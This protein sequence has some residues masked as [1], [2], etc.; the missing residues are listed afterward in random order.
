MPAV[1]MFGMIAAVFAIAVLVSWLYL[2]RTYWPRKSTRDFFAFSDMT[3]MQKL[4]GYFYGVRPDLYLKPAKWPWAVKK[5]EGTTANEYH[6]KVITRRDAAK[7]VKLDRPVSFQASEKVI[8]FPVARSI[9]LEGAPPLAVMECPCRAQKPDACEPR[10]VCMVV[11]EPFVS[12]VLEHR[13]GHARRITTEEA[14]GI[15]EQEEKRGHIH[16][17]WFKT[18][19]HDRFYTICNCCTCCCLGMA[20]YHRDVP[21]ITH[22]GYRPVNDRDGCIECGE[23]E[24]S[25]PFRAVICLEGSPQIN[26]NKCMGCG[27]CVSHCPVGAIKLELAPDRGIPLD[28][29]RLAEE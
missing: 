26:D 3:F 6:G 23:C 29:D 8:P 21:R 13:S 5:L 17:A 24:T 28:L 19:M 1:K 22:S 10:D 2:E 18:V 11:G 9:I 20:S 7:I 16:T 4:E 27:I 14:L 25:C 12:L 15:L